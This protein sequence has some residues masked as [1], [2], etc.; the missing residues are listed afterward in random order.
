M[1]QLER[2]RL[3]QA[4]RGCGEKGA[5]GQPQCLTDKHPQIRMIKK[6]VYRISTDYSEVELNRG[7]SNCVSISIPAC[8]FVSVSAYIYI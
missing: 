7:I 2:Y 6:D 8:I 5:T 4:G 3:D 1:V